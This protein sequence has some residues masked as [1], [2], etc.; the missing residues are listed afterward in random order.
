MFEP[1]MKDKDVRLRSRDDKVAREVV[2]EA[3]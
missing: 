2:R 3:R 1:P